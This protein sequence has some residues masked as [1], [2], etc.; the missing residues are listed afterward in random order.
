MK[1]LTMH[2][3][4]TPQNESKKIN[5]A[6]SQREISG[7][8][9]VIECLERAGVKHVFA[10]PGGA[11]IPLH[12][13]LSHS[14]LDV[15]LPRHEQ[16]GGFMAAGFARATGVTSVCFATSGP[17]A[18]NLV[19]AIA[20]AYADSIPV[21]FITGQVSTQLIGRNAFQE[22]DMIGIT[23][24]IVK[25][26]YL[27]LNIEELPRIMAEAFHLANSGRPGP[28][29]ID[30]PKNIQNAT[31]VPTFID[32]ISIR[33]YCHKHV[34]NF[35]DIEVIREAIK[36]AKRPCL[37]VGGGIVAAGASRELIQFAE[38]YN[39][40]VATTL[41]GVGTIP[42]NHPLSM[43]WL[44][45]HG[46][47][48]AN[49]AVNESDLLLAFGVRFDD[50]VTSDVKTFATQ[51][52]IIHVDIDLSEIN[53]NKRVY[54]GILADVKDVLMALNVS[55]ISVERPE[56][57]AKIAQLRAG[58]QFMYVK[59]EKYVQPQ[60][61]METLSRLTDGQAIIVPGVGQHQMFAAQFYDFKYAR[62]LITSAGFGTMGFGL[63]TAIGVKIA[64]PDKLVVNIDGDGSFQMNIQ[65]LATA[66]AQGLNVKMI[67]FNNQT[68]GMVAQWE[69]RFY[70]SNRAH[71]I[72]SVPK[73][74]KPYPSFVEIAKGYGIPGRD[75]WK[76]EELEDALNEMIH[77]DE[78]FLLDIH[79]PFAD[80][81]LPMI[82]AGK[83]Y[84]DIILE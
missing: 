35:K 2:C 25:H 45:M 18:T 65:E 38:S 71:T 73:F 11:S 77:S 12:Q 50:R 67:I 79:M 10:Y 72:L 76:V 14:K 53:K 32:D 51:A 47:Y 27:V 60:R 74:H 81:V 58:P 30:I 54:Y 83:S 36:K 80:H 41:M 29:V 22:C 52:Q 61:V 19:T 70:H 34:L 9:I 68:L 15:I 33:N 24:S 66:Y 55:P 1:D 3:A 69:D 16:G 20:D 63:P 6:T 37:Y 59:N 5:E 57:E 78:S 31:M 21:I 17:G 8:E 49:I 42:D 48:A 75:V 43:Q 44:G 62:Q 28:I 46:S 40:P 7:A 39:I 56:W 64:R 84:K 26:S 23:R 4:N 13:A 82:P